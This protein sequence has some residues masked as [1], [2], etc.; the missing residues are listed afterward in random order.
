LFVCRPSCVQ[1]CEQREMRATIRMAIIMAFFSCMWLGF[2]IIYTIRGCCS[3][4]QIPRE[5]DTFFFWLGYSNSSVNPILYTIFNDD[6]KRAFVKI[7]SCRAG[8][9]SILGRKWSF[10]SVATSRKQSTTSATISSWWHHASWCRLKCPNGWIDEIIDFQLQSCIILCWFNLS[11]K[12]F[13]NTTV[14]NMHICN[15]CVGLILVCNIGSKELVCKS[16]TL[17]SYSNYTQ[18]PIN[19]RIL[20]GRRELKVYTCQCCDRKVCTRIKFA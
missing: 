4:C 7:L 14:C 13:W 2:F 19:D 5:I 15:Y 1:R 18:Y 12:I 10:D 9:F 20:L 16:V 6:F 11:Y 17:V 3:D 8:E